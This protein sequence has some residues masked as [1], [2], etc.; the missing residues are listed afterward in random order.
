MHIFSTFYEGAQQPHNGTYSRNT[1]YNY[2]NEEL[3]NHPKQAR[4]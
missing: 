2:Y 3:Y 4:Q 1:T